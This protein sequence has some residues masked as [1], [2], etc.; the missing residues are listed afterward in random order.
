LGTVKLGREGTIEVHLKGI[1]CEVVDLTHLAQDR[2]EK[3]VL[4]FRVPK[5]LQVA[6]PDVRLSAC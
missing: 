4:K 1:S 5:R 6:E 2:I 3:Q